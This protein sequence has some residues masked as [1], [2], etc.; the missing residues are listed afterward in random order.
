LVDLF[1]MRYAEGELLYYTRDEAILTRQRRVVTLL[2]GN[3]LVA[4]R[5][6]DVELPWQRIVLLL[7]LVMATIK[8]LVGDLAGDALQFRVV[9]VRDSPGQPSTLRAERELCELVLREWRE[10]GIVEV[11]EATLEAEAA[12]LKAAS[13]RALVLVVVFSAREGTATVE[14]WL[15]AARASRLDERTPCIPVE[16]GLA[17][18]ADL[19]AWKDSAVDLVAALL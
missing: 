1:D 7:G 9:F 11:L 3:D 14:P 10:K 8:K 2:L 15:A 5:V 12:A 18:A 16:T 19:E 6:K 13:R 17:R 4:T